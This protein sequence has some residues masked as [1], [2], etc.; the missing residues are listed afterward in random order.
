MR[1]EIVGA[2]A[3]WIKQRYELVHWDGY[4]PDVTGPGNPICFEFAT[5]S[6]DQ[7]NFLSARIHFW[8][9]GPAITAC[10]LDEGWWVVVP[11]GPLRWADPELFDQLEAII[12]GLEQSLPA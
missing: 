1:N 5:R 6:M 10:D 4:D 12:D 8:E 11:V 2:V 3:S 9:Q 7:N